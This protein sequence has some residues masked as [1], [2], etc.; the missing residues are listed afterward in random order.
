MASFSPT[1]G[2]FGDVTS[3]QKP[4]TR[5][6]KRHK[7]A[8]FSVVGCIILLAGAGLGWWLWQGRYQPASGGVLEEG[9]VGSPQYLN[10]LYSSLNPVDTE[11]TPLIFRGLLTYDSNQ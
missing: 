10:P 11:L 8:L 9:I 7:L 2:K 3:R 1:I 4:W 6:Y 5:W